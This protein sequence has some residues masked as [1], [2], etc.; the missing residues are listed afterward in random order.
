MEEYIYISSGLCPPDIFSD[1]NSIYVT[2]GL[3]PGE[4]S[5]EIATSSV[6]LAQ[7]FYVYN[8]FVPSKASV[9][10]KPISGYSVP[11]FD[12]SNAVTIDA[13]N[14]SQLDQGTNKNVVYTDY[15]D[16]SGKGSMYVLGLDY[17]GS[18]AS[19]YYPIK[20]DEAGT[21]YIYLRGRTSSGRFVADVYVDSVL[22]V[23]FDQIGPVGAWGWF[24]QSFTLTDSSVHTLEIRMKEVENALDRFCISKVAITPDNVNNYQNAYITLHFQIY[25]VNT[26]D[27]PIAPLYIYDYKTTLEE[28]RNS[29]WYNFSLNF[30]EDSLAVPWDSK[31]AI[32]M[33]SSGGSERNYLIWELTDND[34]PYICGP[35]AIK[36]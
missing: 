5:Y 10:I 18:Y 21:V 2:A 25:T 27:E 16:F 13:L 8:Q 4:V 9:Y 24:G 34:N 33:F 29:D 7:I 11:Y 3:L 17:S 15:E 23:S 30:L 12:V 36:V 6:K 20:A 26:G 32:V 22:V 19:L 35:S 31:Y 14:F 28:L 1:N